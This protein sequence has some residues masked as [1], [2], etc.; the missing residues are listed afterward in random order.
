MSQSL[1]VITNADVF[2]PEPLGR[3]DL[4]L[5]GSKIIKIGKN[6]RSIPN[7]E[8]FGDVEVIDAQG[9]FVVPGYIDQHV[10]IAGG[11]GAA[12]YGSRG[13][14]V[15][16]SECMIAGT[17]T[18]IGCMG[19]DTVTR[20]PIDL[21]AKAR[22]LKFRGMSAYV[23]TGGFNVPPTL[24]TDNVRKDI[25]LVPEII[26]IGE[27]AVSDF[28]GRHQTPQELAQ[29][30]TDVLV[31]GRMSGKAGVVHLHLG[32]NQTGLDPVL[33]AVKLGEIPI[34]YILP[35]HFNRTEKLMQ[36]AHEWAGMGGFV[37]VS[38]NLEP[39]HYPGS[40]NAAEAVARLI[41]EGMSE[42]RITLSTDGNGVHTLYG[43]ETAHRFPLSL[44]HRDVRAMVQEHGVPLA[45]ALKAVTSNVAR[46][47]KLNHKG[48]IAEGNDADLL[49]MDPESLDI[50]G[51]IAR[52]VV[53][54]HAGAFIGR[55]TLDV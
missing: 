13:P 25:W 34:E 3:N 39:P 53:Q 38:S 48:R 15:T 27:A 54:V 7:L 49:L 16:F 18:V 2:A 12:G 43:Y 55:H 52:G 11:G 31:A 45:T 44:L 29:L 24:I 28:R 20:S 40:T 37:D 5:L 14:E 21:V 10:H 8:V 47:T 35:T 51:V 22:S 17:T 36:Q 33:A 6:L 1:T 4:L 42:E 26:G 19:I 23:Y 32:P 30:F 46:A 9:A 41:G 50:T